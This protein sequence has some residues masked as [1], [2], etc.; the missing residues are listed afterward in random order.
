MTETRQQLGERLRTAREY[1]GLTQQEA[2]DAVGLSRTAISLIEGAERKLETFE[3]KRLAALYQRPIIDFTGGEVE[4]DLPEDLQL[5]LR[6]AGE[7]TE[8]DRAEIVR[9]ADWL[10]A[11]RESEPAE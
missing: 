4:R 10:L 6:K 8:V 11:R 2:G 5:L 7:M 9:F 1:L 3:L